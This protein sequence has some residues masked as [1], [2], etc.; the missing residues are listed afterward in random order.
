MLL[1]PRR[2]LYS[3]RRATEERRRLGYRTVISL[4]ALVVGAVALSWASYRPEATIREVRVSGVKS[5]SEGEVRDFVFAALSGTRAKIFNKANSFLYP[6]HAVEEGLLSAFPRLK[7]AVVSRAGLAALRITVEERE[8]SFL[9]CGEKLPVGTE[10][11]DCY[12]L[13]RDGIA[14]TRAPYFSG[15]VYFEMYGAL[16]GG[17]RFV[18]RTGDFATIGH[19][20]LPDTEWRR[21]L[22]FKDALLEAGIPVKKI[23]VEQAGGDAFFIFPSGVRF[24]FSFTQDF[25]AVLFNLLAALE[26]EPL[27][28]DVFYATD[29]SAPLE[30]LDARFENRIFYK[31]F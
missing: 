12:F 16:S 13:D 2:P 28:D 22:A 4:V 1:L 18:P 21:L 26:T 30:Y 6:R 31:G 17:P 23:V 25:N 19:P 9:W 11:N 8:P 3:E 27:T 24:I 7:E 15:A 10:R 14:F 5:L 20:F 29:G